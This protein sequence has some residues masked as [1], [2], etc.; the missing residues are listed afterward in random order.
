MDEGGKPVAEGGGLGT[1]VLETPHRNGEHGQVLT[2]E[3]Q[4][5]FL[6]GRR[7]LRFAYES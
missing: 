2:G 3:L 6:V 5:G 4:A 1:V 7:V